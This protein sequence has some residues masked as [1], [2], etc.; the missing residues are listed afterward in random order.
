[1]LTKF[2]RKE[3][4]QLSLRFKFRTRLFSVDNIG[5]RP[6]YNYLIF[7]IGTVF[8]SD[9]KSIGSPLIYTLIPIYEYIYITLYNNL[10]YTTYQSPYATIHHITTYNS[11]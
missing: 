6:S 11:M 10:P 2:M 9:Y 8:S 3:G 5:E 7:P 4:P 1:M